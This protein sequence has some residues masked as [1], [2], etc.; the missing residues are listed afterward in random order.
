MSLQKLGSRVLSLTPGRTKQHK[1]KDVSE[2]FC[3]CFVRLFCFLA[4]EEL[5]LDWISIYSNNWQ[6]L[7][8]GFN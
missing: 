5:E 8:L 2:S 7:I 1:E 4:A 6:L 3:L